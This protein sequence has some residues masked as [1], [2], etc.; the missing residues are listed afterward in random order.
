MDYE[1][2]N[3]E[4]DKYILNRPYYSDSYYD[5]FYGELNTDL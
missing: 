5:S 4:S 1:E 2:M 3:P